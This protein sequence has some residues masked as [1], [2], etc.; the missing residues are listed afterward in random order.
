VGR[1]HDQLNGKG[2]FLNN[3]A[4]EVRGGPAHKNT[5][6]SPNR[7]TK[8]KP[9][10]PLGSKF[11]NEEQIK[12]L[13]FGLLEAEDISRTLI[14]LISNGFPFKFIIDASNIPT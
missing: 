12:A 8:F 7:G 5:P 1:G 10:K 6:R 9:I 14:Y 3:R 2:L 4:R 13:S 11:S